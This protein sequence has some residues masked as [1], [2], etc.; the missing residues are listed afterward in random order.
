M[1]MQEKDLRKSGE[2]EEVEIKVFGR[3]RDTILS[4][5]IGEK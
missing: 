4:R 2:D 1:K 5:E 3:G